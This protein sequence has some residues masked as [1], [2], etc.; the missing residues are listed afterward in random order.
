MKKRWFKKIWI[1]MF[2]TGMLVLSCLG[3]QAAGPE[4]IKHVNKHPVFSILT[5]SGW[6]NADKVEGDY[7]A[8]KTGA[9]SLPNL[10]VSRAP[11]YTANATLKNLTDGA[12]AT[13]KERY[14]GE[15]FEILYTREIKLADQTKA[16][17]AGIK[18]KHPQVGLYSAYLWAMKGTDGI[19][20]IATDMEP[21]SDTLKAYLYT[22]VIK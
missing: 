17:E 12:I 20:V 11:Y 22:L 3:V 8:L 7:V 5:P 21:V 15:D 13:L 2:A 6:D 10:Y 9:Y 19:V 1:S 14:Q 18:W 4:G 16:F